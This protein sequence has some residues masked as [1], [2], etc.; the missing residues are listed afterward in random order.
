MKVLQINS[1]CGFGSTGRIATDLADILLSRGDDCRIAYGRG[2][3]PEAYASI[4]VKI[5]SSLN[6]AL[7]GVATRALDLH[8]LWSAAATRQL[9]KY[10][11][12][13]QP[14]LIH[15]H[16]LHGYYLHVGRLFAYLKKA[17]IPVVWT[18]HDCWTMT[19]HCAHFT[20]VGC[21]QYKTACR[22]CPQYRTYPATLSGAFVGRNFRR[23]KQAFSGVKN[24]TIVTPSHW[25]AAVTRDSFLQQYPVVPIYNGLDLNV[26]KPTDSDFR[27]THGIGDR[28]MVLGVANVWEGYKGLEDFVRLSEMLDDRYRIVL[29]GLSEAQIAALP[30]TII[31]L[32]RTKTVQE[33]AE[34]YTAADVYVNPSIEETMGLT[35]AEALACGTPV[36]T[37]NKTA[38]PEVADATCGIVVDPDPALVAEALERVDFPAA[39]CIARARCFEKQQQYDK[40]MDVYQQV[41]RKG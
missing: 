37:Y 10:I 7:H 2:T 39:A 24:L 23:K 15:L 38:V 3:A 35:T 17:D 41:V 11:K 4:A 1:V 6:N 29:V 27:T 14:D 20:A 19:G 5:G 28:K 26:F 33:L 25:L 36:I 30:D 13:Y 8:G 18:L 32:P 12:A 31:K 21:E 16:N 34:I 40:Y 9:I 22:R